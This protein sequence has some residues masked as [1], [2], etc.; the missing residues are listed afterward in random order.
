[1]HLQVTCGV[2]AWDGIYGVVCTRQ[3]VV[4]KI[5][6]SLLLSETILNIWCLYILLVTLR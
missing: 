4:L 3:N 2:T 1:M 6:F 5:T